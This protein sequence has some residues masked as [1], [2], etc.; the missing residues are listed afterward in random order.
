M[1]YLIPALAATALL[2]ALFAWIRSGA[3]SARLDELERD[4]IRR[5]H[6]L[7]AET[8]RGLEL[9]R[10]LLTTLALG[11][12][13]EAEMI[14][15]GRLLR[16]VSGK[17][18]LTLVNESKARILDV[19]TPRETV[20]GFAEN[21]IIIPVDELEARAHELPKDGKPLVIY[22]AAGVR[23]AAACEYLSSLGHDGLYNLA[24]GF[25]A[26]TGPRATS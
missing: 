7:S 21:A 25:A 20:A 26:W 22:C 11:G 23:S 13:L 16:D 19:R 17:E 2:L 4:L 1:E 24:G 3:Q 12:E 6:D 18:A 8:E 14:E 15:E 5:S 10:R 9:Q